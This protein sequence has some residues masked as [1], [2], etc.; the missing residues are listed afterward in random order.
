MTIDS[1]AAAPPSVPVP[2][3]NG[4]LAR[5][6][7]EGTMVRPSTVSP[8]P[9]QPP[10]QGE[11]IMKALAQAYPDRIGPAEFRNGDWAVPIRGTWYYYASG[12]LLP[13]ELRSRA[14]EYDPQ[15]FYTY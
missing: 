13:Q 6:A 15:P 2:V 12:R 11:R 7:A 14:A 10:S 4:L 1:V 3:E 8:P 5:G 9:Q